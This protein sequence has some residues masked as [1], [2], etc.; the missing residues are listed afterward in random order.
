MPIGAV[1]VLLL[2]CSVAS[3]FTGALMIGTHICAKLAKRV[4]QKQ[5]DYLL[6]V[7]E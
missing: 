4:G 5:A 2:V 1:V 6:R 3:W 7:E